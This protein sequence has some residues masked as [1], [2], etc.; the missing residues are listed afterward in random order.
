MGKS[1]VFGG[2]AVTGL[3]EFL[4]ACP[5]QG[6]V[7]VSTFHEWFLKGQVRIL[8]D[9][10]LELGEGPTILFI[11]SISLPFPEDLT[12]LPLCQSDQSKQILSKF[13]S[14]FS[15]LL[16]LRAEYIAVSIKARAFKRILNSP[17][18]ETAHVVATRAR[19]ARAVMVFIVGM[20][21][22]ARAMLLRGNKS[23]ERDREKVIC[24]IHSC[25][26]I[27]HICNAGSHPH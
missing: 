2:R 17:G 11:F 7:M 23:R 21:E 26:Y 13:S 1:L 19:T 8:R 10:D 27:V 15:I 14:N 12:L 25:V 22:G 6:W 18:G 3:Q 5:G 9:P 16:L 24:L 20:N 4:W